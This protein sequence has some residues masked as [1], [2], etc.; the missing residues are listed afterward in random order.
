MEYLHVD[1]SEW[2]YYI[3][4]LLDYHAAAIVQPLG[5]NL[6]RMLAGE[7]KQQHTIEMGAE[8]STERC[9]DTSSTKRC[10]ASLSCEKEWKFSRVKKAIIFT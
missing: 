7:G 10:E 5:E 1:R 9:Y 8:G 2:V 4:S 3:V 6:I